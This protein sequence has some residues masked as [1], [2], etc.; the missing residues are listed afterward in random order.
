MRPEVIRFAEEME[1]VLKENDFRGGWSCKEVSIQYLE[2][3]LVEEMGKYFKYAAKEAE[4]GASD[5][6]KAKKELIDIA[7]FALM[8]HSRL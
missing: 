1:K 6:K 7:N 3:R 8:A 4:V 2:Y 5:N